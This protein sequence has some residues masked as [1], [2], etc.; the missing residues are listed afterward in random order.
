MDDDQITQHVAR[1]QPQ[2]LAAQ[3][4]EQVAEVLRQHFDDDADVLAICRRLEFRDFDG[5]VRADNIGFTDIGAT[6]FYADRHRNHG[7][8]LCVSAELQLIACS[9]PDARFAVVERAGIVRHRLDEM[10]RTR[11]DMTR[12]RG[13]FR[14]HGRHRALR[15]VPESEF[16]AVSGRYFRDLRFQPHRLN[17]IN[18]DCGADG[19][20]RLLCLNAR[21]WQIAI[22]GIPS[23]R[24]DGEPG[25]MLVFSR[26]A[27]FVSPAFIAAMDGVGSEIGGRL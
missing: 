1:L 27:G 16:H 8:T 3:N 9:M 18:A 26:W 5:Q 13:H 21:Q 14:I 19:G 2:I 11:A 24:L 15:P 12:P 20:E 23:L 17:A 25:R 6:Y 22:A 10:S 7:I 4:I